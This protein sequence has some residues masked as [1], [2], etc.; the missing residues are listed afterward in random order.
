VS[1]STPGA[2][3]A[4]AEARLANCNDETFKQIATKT[5]LDNGQTWSN[6]K[7]VGSTSD[8]L[9]NPE[10][11]LVH[12]PAGRGNTGSPAFVIV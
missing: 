12:A 10:A 11:V 3:I 9:F 8:E 4:I 1:G 7:L 2:L 5:S 6:L